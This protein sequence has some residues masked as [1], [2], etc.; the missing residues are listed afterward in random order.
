V[1]ER[2]AKVDRMLNAGSDLSK[3]LDIF[4]AAIKHRP[5]FG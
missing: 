1:D 2:R 5:A 4:T 3:A